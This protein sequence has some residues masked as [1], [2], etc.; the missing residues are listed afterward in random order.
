MKRTHFL[1]IVDVET[2]NIETFSHSNDVKTTNESWEELDK[3]LNEHIGEIDF[4]FDVVSNSNNTYN[5]SKT[6]NAQ[7]CGT[8]KDQKKAFTL[9]TVYVGNIN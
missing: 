3:L 2:Q 1:T 8:S 9:I 5:S 7:Y 4:K 6:I